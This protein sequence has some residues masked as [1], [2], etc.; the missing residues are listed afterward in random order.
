MNNLKLNSKYKKIPKTYTQVDT[1][2][3]VA[4]KVLGILSTKKRPGFQ[5][6]LL[7]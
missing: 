7:F 5:K 2:G 4:P 6:K 1:V 3:Y